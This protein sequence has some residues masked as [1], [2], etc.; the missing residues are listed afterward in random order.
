MAGRVLHAGQ[1]AYEIITGH[2]T[3][4]VMQ[5]KRIAPKLGYDELIGVAA[6]SM[7]CTHVYRVHT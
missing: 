6:S 1:S 2:S 5:L 4:G 7:E 3:E